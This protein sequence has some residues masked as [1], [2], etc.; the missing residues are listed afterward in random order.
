[1]PQPTPLYHVALLVRD[2]D[3]AM[4]HFTELLGLTF[5]TPRVLTVHVD[6]HRDATELRLVYSSEGPPY[7]ELIEATP[8]G[9]WSLPAGAP[10]AFHHIG[11]WA[12]DLDHRLDDPERSL[13]VEAVMH[14]A[15]GTRG[16]AFLPPAEH[17]GARVEL[18]SPRQRG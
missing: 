10:D 11:C 1:M 13:A 3:A 18:V 16:A 6:G 17:H 9:F 4:E 7:L 12:H 2:L 8:E 14:R 5:P 15:D